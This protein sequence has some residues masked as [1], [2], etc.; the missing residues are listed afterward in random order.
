MTKALLLVIAVG[1]IL[2]FC[3][4]LAK[5]A[6]GRGVDALSFAFWQSLGAGIGLTLLCGARGVR[7]PVDARHLRYALI[8][9]CL[10]LAAP[11]VLAYSAVTR[12]GS[13]LLG[14]VYTLP[15]IV[16]YAMMLALRRERFEAM[17][18][19][20]IALGLIGAVL[21]VGLRGGLPDPAMWSWMLAALG[22]PVLLAMGNVYR[23]V[24]WPVGASGQA[25]AAATLLGSSAILAAAALAGGHPIHRPGLDDWPIAAV[26]LLT[27]LGYLLYFELQRVAG[28]VYLSF[29]GYLMILVGVGFGHA[30]WDERLPPL[31]WLAIGVIAA[32]LLLVNRRKPSAA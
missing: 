12:I 1:T 2:G 16:T 10:T 13:G 9:G 7:A 29:I 21:I 14:I 27:G 17:R 22:V 11:H 23:T 19:A 8:G 30:V 25:L 32:G 5:I 24:D 18:A 3:P 28:P 20:G 15:P 6:A 4:P 26:V 31:T